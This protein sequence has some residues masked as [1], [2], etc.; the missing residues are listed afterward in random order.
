MRE[1][2]LK[3]GPDAEEMIGLYTGTIASL[4]AILH[5]EGILDG[6]G[7]AKAKSPMKTPLG[8]A[9]QEILSTTILQAVEQIE[10]GAPPSGARP[11]LSI[12]RAAPE[13]DG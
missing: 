4:V 12:V 2:I 3:L 13:D 10:N 6:R 11:T 7:F 1:V 5:G 9:M 8:Q